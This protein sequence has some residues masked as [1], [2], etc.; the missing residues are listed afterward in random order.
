MGQN[1]SVFKCRHLTLL[2]QGG[3]GSYWRLCRWCLRMRRNSTRLSLSNGLARFLGRSS[4]AFEPPMAV[5]LR[6]ERSWTIIAKDYV[7]LTGA[8]IDNAVPRKLGKYHH[9]QQHL[10]YKDGS[11]DDSK[12]KYDLCYDD[13]NHYIWPLR[14]EAQCLG[15]LVLHFLFTIKA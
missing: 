8:V 15:R 12:W 14:T 10:V 11:D 6:Q 13:H 7:S 4:K 5:D 1:C 9:Q 2:D 3:L